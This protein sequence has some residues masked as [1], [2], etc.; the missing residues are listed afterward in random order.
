M[1]WNMPPDDI[2]AMHITIKAYSDKIHREYTGNV[3][4]SRVLD[5]FKSEN[6]MIPIITVTTNTVFIPDL[7]DV[8]EVGR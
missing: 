4:N 2:D 5:H 1:G 3:S 8:H 6:F 7:I